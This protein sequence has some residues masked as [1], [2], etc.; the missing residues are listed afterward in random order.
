MTR[1]DYI[2]LA[3]VIKD[4]TIIDNSKMLRHNNINKATLISDLIV[5][6]KKDNSLFDR[7]KFIDACDV[8]DK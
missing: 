3:R 2:M 8:E 1:K 5:L 6:L 7:A 4:N